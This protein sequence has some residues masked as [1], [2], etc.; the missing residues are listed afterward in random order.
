[1]PPITENKYKKC[2]HWT[3][4]SCVMESTLKEIKL[5]CKIIEIYHCLGYNVTR[6]LRSNIFTLS[7]SNPSKFS[8]LNFLNVVLSFISNMFG[9]T[10]M[11]VICCQTIIF[12]SKAVKNSS[13]CRQQTTDVCYRLVELT[14]HYNE[15]VL[16]DIMDISVTRNNDIS[17]NLVIVAI[18]NP[19]APQS[20]RNLQRGTMKSFAQKSR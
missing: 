8:T 19:A 18:G 5:F 15:K 13:L 12:R 16:S 17:H 6:P 2:F 20:G 3:K 4:V 9:V 10:L 1:M 11:T 14:F 7:L